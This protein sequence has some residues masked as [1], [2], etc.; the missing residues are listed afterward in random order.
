MRTRFDKLFNSF[1]AA[2]AVLGLVAALP[3][4]PAFASVDS[5][6]EVS[7][8][9]GTRD[10]SS[11][12]Y[13]EFKDLKLRVSQ[14][15]N[16][17]NQGLT[18]SWS[19]MNPTIPG[20][21]SMN[22]MQIMQCWGDDSGPTPQQCQWGGTPAAMASKLG[23][24]AGARE[25]AEGE[26]QL[27]TYDSN[28]LI[29]PPRNRPNQ[30]A[31]RVPFITVDGVKTFNFLQYF[32]S[33][34]SNEVSGAVVGGD[35][36]GQA[37]FEV[38]TVYEA[39]H[40]GCG[41]LTDSGPRSCWL[42]VVPRGMHN[43]DG[44]VADS[45][46]KLSGS[47]LSA[48]NWAQRIQVKLNFGNITAVCPIGNS[49]RRI[50]GNDIAAAAVTSWQ[51][52]LCK[53]AAT[54]GYSQM[55]DGE[56]RRL[57]VSNYDGVA[58]LALV[59]SPF[60]EATLGTNHVMYAPA[61]QSAV[62][63]AFNI[64]RNLNSDAPNFAQNGTLLDNLTLNPRL[65]AKLLTQSYQREVPGGFKLD[66][67]ATNPRSLTQDPEFLQ[68]NP[69]FESFAKNSVPDGLLVSLGSS[70]A[71]RQIWKWIQNDS[72]ALKFLQ[73]NPD[74]WGMVIN[75]YYLDLKL[76]ADTEIESF[77][78]ADLSTYKSNQQDPKEFGTLDMRPYMNDMLDAALATRRAD[79]RIKTYWD[80]NKVPPAFAAD[81]SASAQ[82]VGQHFMISITSLPA[83]KR[84]GLGV[85]SLVNP[86][87]QAISPN[88]DSIS[89]AI[90]HQATD[91]VS[92]VGIYDPSRLKSGDY[93][94]ASTTYAVVNPCTQT[95]DSLKDYSDFLEYA[96]GLG[97]VSGDAQGDLP[98]G[99]VPLSSDQTKQTKDL[100]K[101][102]VNAGVQDVCK[103]SEQNTDNT[104]GSTTTDGSLIPEIPY[105]PGIIDTPISPVPNVEPKVVTPNV[106]ETAFQGPGSANAIIMAASVFGIPGFLSG[107]ILLA[108]I[109]R[110]KRTAT[111]Q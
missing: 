91:E 19:G 38:Q 5:S 14:T 104:G 2:L 11:V 111:V 57:L 67:L 20:E 99:Y 44:T 13:E 8:D 100:A 72:D 4:Q 41:D 9:D 69:E 21:F 103:S 96:A 65:V 79:A 94:L 56:A 24:Q 73:G 43:A 35:G 98:Q 6:R 97:Q 31:Y 30:K 84:Y 62:V 66:Y 68:L 47:P 18:V 87:G 26:D 39:P 59:D 17:T 42:V 81:P 75:K 1:L 22:Y 90:A 85:A 74:P 88:A 46:N 40:L 25:L 29:P 106:F 82:S 34:S 23:S 86:N 89:S 16:L 93:P 3:T 10:A 64:D 105:D 51:P 60:D 110:K 108:R 12:Q 101:A 61:T 7:W 80:L 63:I 102:L 36:T 70:D 28:F 49:E 15:E 27:Q 32:D 77:P 78:K 76:D 95:T 45:S 92:K 71:N 107:R 50:V 54:F 37:V 55:G 109:R 83:A 52:A 53:S 48:T 33:F 58:G